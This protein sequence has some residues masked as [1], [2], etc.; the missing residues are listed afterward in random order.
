MATYHVTSAI[1]HLI[2]GIIVATGT[3]WGPAA[4]AAT[5]ASSLNHPMA[6]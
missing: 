2:A 3:G 1:L 4:K 5:T 6:S